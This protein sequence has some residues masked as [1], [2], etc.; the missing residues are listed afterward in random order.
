[1]RKKF[2]GSWR[3]NDVKLYFATEKKNEETHTIKYSLFKDSAHS[4]VTI[5]ARSL[6][7]LLATVAV[8]ALTVPATRSERKCLPLKWESSVYG[9][10]TEMVQGTGVV[11]DIVATI[12]V[13]NSKNQTAF[14]ES[15]Y[16]GGQFAGDYMVL[17][18]NGDGYLIDTINMGCTKFQSQGMPQLCSDSNQ[19]TDTYRLAV[20]D[21][22]T[23]ITVLRDSFTI[24]SELIEQT[25]AGVS[26][27]IAFQYGNMTNG[28]QDESVFDIPSYCPTTV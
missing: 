9:K 5:L 2:R 16:V 25:F 7:L 15:V 13:D 8:S 1:M 23:V 6:C 11:S 10:L 4:I 21:R 19:I 17:Y 26:Q 27:M 22:P 18:I 28:I 24:V 20:K 12:S 3:S 14:R